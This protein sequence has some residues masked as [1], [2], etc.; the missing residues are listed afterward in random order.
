MSYASFFFFQNLLVLKWRAGYYWYCDC[1]T[2]QSI[3]LI[4]PVNLVV[5]SFSPQIHIVVSRVAY[6]QPTNPIPQVYT[7]RTLFSST[8]TAAQLATRRRS[9]PD[10]ETINRGDEK[11]KYPELNRFPGAQVSS[12]PVSFRD[13]HQLRRTRILL[14][15]GFAPQ[16]DYS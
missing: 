11:R 1:G 12:S 13:L 3:Q 2:P 9:P 6:P 16:A 4:C 8:A 5:S 14:G 10:Q 15:S 7:S